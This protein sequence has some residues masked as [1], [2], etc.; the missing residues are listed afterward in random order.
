MPKGMRYA[1]SAF[2]GFLVCST[3]ILAPYGLP[4]WAAAEPGP[5]DDPPPAAPSGLAGPSGLT[6]S[7]AP[8]IKGERRTGAYF[9]PGCPEY[10]SLS[11]AVVVLFATEE[12]ARRAGFHKAQNCP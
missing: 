10:D 5:T 4:A 12:E 3:L 1:T 6:V 8:P 11:S 7:P 9:P 2:S